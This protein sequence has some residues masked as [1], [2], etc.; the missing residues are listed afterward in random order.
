MCVFVCLCIYAEHILLCVFQ[1]SVFVCQSICVNWLCV[2]VCV[3]ALRL[4]VFEMCI[5][6]RVCGVSLQVYLCMCV[7]VAF[8]VPLFNTTHSPKWVT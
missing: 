2:C 6:V 4:H 1:M 5:C 7:C 8:S 3:C